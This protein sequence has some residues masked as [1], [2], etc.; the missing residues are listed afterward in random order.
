MR[1]LRVWA[2]LWASWAK[3]TPKSIP[4]SRAKRPV[5]NYQYELNAAKANRKVVYNTR[6][7]N[8]AWVNTTLW[9]S[10]ASDMT[11]RQKNIVYNADR[12]VKNAEK[13]VK[14]SKRK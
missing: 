8:A 13:L 1:T 14:L 7:T 3:L 6:V 2:R 10:R 11:Q 4:V 12:R 5:K 9:Q